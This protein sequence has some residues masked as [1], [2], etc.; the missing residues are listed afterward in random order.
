[1]ELGIAATFLT[2][3]ICSDLLNNLQFA[4]RQSEKPCLMS[5]YPAISSQL[6]DMAK[7]WYRKYVICLYVLTQDDYISW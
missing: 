4:I 1:M 7:F 3:E 6:I 5:W 2:T